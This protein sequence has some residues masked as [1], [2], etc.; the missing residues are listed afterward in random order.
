ME[1]IFAFMNLDHIEKF[2]QMH[3]I[4]Q[5]QPFSQALAIKYIGNIGKYICI[6]I[7]VQCIPHQF[8]RCHSA[9]CL[10]NHM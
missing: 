1:S 8:H 5:H 6:G 10:T 2:L 4:G 9:F 3:S 7:A